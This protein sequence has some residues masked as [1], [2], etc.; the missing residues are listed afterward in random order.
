MI[1]YDGKEKR[2]RGLYNNAPACC[3]NC[4]FI[5]D[6][7]QKYIVNIEYGNCKAHSPWN[8]GSAIWPVVPVNSSPCGDYKREQRTK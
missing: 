6:V 2:E 1:M 5:K 7:G 4:R 3:G 8:P